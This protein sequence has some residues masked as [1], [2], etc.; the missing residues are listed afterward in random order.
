MTK[1]HAPTHSAPMDEG[2]IVQEARIKFLVC[3]GTGFIGRHMA[4]SLADNP[5]YEVTAT[6]HSRPPFAHPCIKW[7]E[8]DLRSVHAVNKIIQGQDIVI[9]AAAVTS[10]A[11]DIVEQPHIHVCDNAVMNSLILRAAYDHAVK[12]FIFFSCSI[13]YPGSAVPLREED[14]DAHS[15]LTPKYFG[16]GWTKVYMEKMCEFYTRLGRTRHTVIRHSN[17][18]G[19]YDKFDLHRSHVCGALITK[20]MTSTGG[21]ITIWGD[22]KEQ[23]DLVYIDDLVD[24]VHRA[25]KRQRSRFGLYNVGS[26]KL[27]SVET[28]AERII[29]AS[30]RSLTIR[31]APDRPTIKSSIC[32]DCNRAAADFGW[33]PRTELDQG[34][35][36][37]I[38]WYQQHE[39]NKSACHG[40]QKK[41]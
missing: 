14:F 6:Y 12:H 38:Q 36:K 9:Q 4:T 27:I 41:N 16:A 30:G 21:V 28:L 40:R 18:Y 5:R 29:E 2:G 31:Y 24:F 39:M 23:R 17:V 11:K 13:M 26:G 10:G 22:G 37:T 8:A 3:G 25:F 33:S 1:R 35:L 19:P 7:V 20:A 34:L 15:E 32:L